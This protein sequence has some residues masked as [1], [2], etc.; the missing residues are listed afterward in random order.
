MKDSSS[1]KKRSAFVAKLYRDDDDLNELKVL[2]GGDDNIDS[3]FE[4]KHDLQIDSE[5]T[6]QRKR[7]QKMKK[8]SDDKSF[9]GSDVP[10][11]KIGRLVSQ[12]QILTYYCRNLKKGVSHYS[13]STKYIPIN[14][15]L[16]ITLETSKATF[17]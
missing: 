12:M 5:N 9:M 14:T 8:K 17:R 2:A 16:S 4:E 1:G 10:S 7:E 11:T 3:D 6:G 13:V 15:P